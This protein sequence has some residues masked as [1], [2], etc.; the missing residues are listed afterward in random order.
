[1]E[2]TKST[3]HKPQSASQLGQVLLG[4]MI[5][6]VMVSYFFI[7]EPL[8]SLKGFFSIV[9]VAALSFIAAV[10]IHELGHAVAGKFVGMEV[11]NLSFGPFIYAKSTGR[12]RF[13]VKAP[14]MGYVGRAMMRFAEPLPDEVMRTK[15]IRF[16]YGGPAANL[17]VGIP[18][19]ILS[20][21]YG[22]S[23][24]LTFAIVQLF[25]GFS[26]LMNAE[27]K[28]AQTDGRVIAMLKNHVEGADLLF[29]S[30]RLIQE[31]PS[32]NGNWSEETIA[33]AR[34]VIERYENWPLA[35]SLLSSIG[36]YYYFSDTESYLELAK[37]RSFLARDAQSGILQDLTDTA[38]ATALYFAGRLQDEP[39]IKRK[40][41]LIGNQDA[42]SGHLRDVYVAIWQGN[43]A[44]ALVALDQVEHALGDWHPLYLE[45]LSLK[46]TISTIRI[47]LKK[48]LHP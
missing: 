41:Q 11:M 4:G 30:Y 5:G 10:I 2:N 6:L 40:L 3:L 33:R 9:L 27:V 34:S 23:G 15:L 18:L 13:Y 22:W 8:F 1:M 48:Q 20:F 24:W 29:V 7:H 28:G 31:D 43:P 17:V 19:I 21:I 16:I 47:D 32:G 12:S 45:G 42:V 39:G 14:A 37:G 38:V 44:D 36:P 46:R 35:Y 26:N 25:L